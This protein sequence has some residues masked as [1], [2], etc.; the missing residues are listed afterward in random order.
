MGFLLEVRGP[1][2]GGVLVECLCGKKSHLDQLNPILRKFGSSRE[3]G[4]A[5]MFEKK[6]IIFAEMKKGATFDD[7]ES[8]A[9]EMGAEEVNL[10][11]ENSL[12][13]ITGEYDL[14]SVST[15]LTKAGYT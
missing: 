1:G 14:A 3:L 2:R 8:D 5:N 12:E 13:F 10:V 4:I 7:A 11:E 15:E 9:I 6:G